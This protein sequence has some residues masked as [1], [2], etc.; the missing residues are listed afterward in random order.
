MLLEYTTYTVSTVYLVL[1]RGL[2]E[3]LEGHGVDDAS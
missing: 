1:D 2:V 3:S